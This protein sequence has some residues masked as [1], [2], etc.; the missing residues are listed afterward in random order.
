MR[1]RNT[2]FSAEAQSGIHSLKEWAELS[3]SES[4]ISIASVCFE[5]VGG[6]GGGVFSFLSST[7]FVCVFNGLRI[8]SESCYQCYEGQRSRTRYPLVSNTLRF[9]EECNER[10]LV[11]K[12]FLDGI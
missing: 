4:K 7:A 8:A 11:L 5:G 12:L 1:C 2:V 10:L 9:R 3:S 6:G